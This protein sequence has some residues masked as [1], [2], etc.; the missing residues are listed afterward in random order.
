MEHKTLYDINISQFSDIIKI[1]LDTKS[2]RYERELQI[3]S[4]LFPEITEDELV[5]MSLEWVDEQITSITEATTG[6]VVPTLT[7]QDKEYRLKG[8]ADD[9]KVNFGQFRAFTTSVQKQLSDYL[10]LYMATVYVSD[11]TTVEERARIFNE[12][13]PFA[14]VVVPMM[15]LNR[16]IS[17]RVS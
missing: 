6:P 17:R 2:P 10:S 9:F 13:M 1:E 7:I 12:Y 16:E 3:L 11:D 5:D 14:Y 8:N 4:I 15:T